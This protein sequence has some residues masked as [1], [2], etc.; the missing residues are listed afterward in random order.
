MVQRTR[1]SLAALVGTVALVGG[2]LL[3]G[4]APALA[5][6]GEVEE[7]PLSS[8]EDVPGAGLAVGPEGNIW[9]TADAYPVGKLGLI[10]PEGKILEYPVPTTTGSLTEPEHSFPDDIAQGPGGVMWFT[11]SGTNKEGEQL[12]GQVTL[13]GGEPPQIKEFPVPKENYLGEIAAGPDGN[14]WFTAITGVGGTAIGRITAK[15]EV[16]LYPLPIIKPYGGGLGGIAQGPGGYMWFTERAENNEHEAFVGRIGTGV[17]GA[18]LGEV[19]ELPIPTKHSFPSGIAA[20]PGGNMWF[21]EAGQH[22][23]GEVTPAGEI[24]Q[25]FSATSTSYSPSGIAEGPDGNM[26]FT[27]ETTNSIGRI[28]PSGEVKGFPV[29]VNNSSPGGIVKGSDGN[30]WFVDQTPTEVGSTSGSFFHIGRLTVPYLPVNTALPAISGTA[31]AGQALTTSQGAWTNNPKSFAYQWLECD[32]SGN[33]CSNLSGETGVTHFLTPA[34][35]GH[36]LRVT[37]TATDVAGSASATSAPSAVIAAPPPPPPPVPRIESPMTWTFGWT[38]KYTVVQSL[39][40]HEVPKGGRVEVVCHGHGCPFAHHLSATVARHHSHQTC[41]SHKKK[42]KAKKPPPQG[43]EVS[44]TRLFKG[45]HLRVGDTISVSIVKAGWVGKSF[46]FTTRSG[47][48]PRVQVSCLAPGS[49]QPGKG[50]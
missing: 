14:M 48:T 47:K 7:F 5:P 50:C 10:T 37:V 46:V 4:P 18:T 19:K 43:P 20:G 33:N 23:I 41:N 24:K 31:T 36:T 42:C 17:D 8:M 13:K 32:T 40:V 21:V 49:S 25:E 35:V 6:P 34:D 9:F 45:S 26:W 44:L 22:E 27:Q 39:V 38:R 11:D 16:S 2:L 28:T 1:R 15:G 30:M 12:I 3:A 29:A